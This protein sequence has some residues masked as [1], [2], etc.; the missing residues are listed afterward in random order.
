MCGEFES[1]VIVFKV[2]TIEI[3]KEVIPLTNSRN[4]LPSI[5][6]ARRISKFRSARAQVR[7]SRLQVNRHLSRYTPADRR[8][9]KRPVVLSQ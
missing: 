7:L 3:A 4:A 2:L 8:A 5:S 1:V 9:T 6:K